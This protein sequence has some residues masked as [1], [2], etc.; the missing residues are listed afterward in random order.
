MLYSITASRSLYGMVSVDGTVYSWYLVN[1]ALWSAV[2]RAVRNLCARPAVGTRVLYT[3]YAHTFTRYVTARP[4]PQFTHRRSHAHTRAKPSAN[5]HSAIGRLLS[6]SRPGPL[7]SFMR[8]WGPR[9]SLAQSA[10]LTR[11]T[12]DRR[13]FTACSTRRTCTAYPASRCALT[14]WPRPLGR[15]RRTTLQRRC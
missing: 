8:A 7:S 15:V 2:C 14:A 5:A 3:E 9:I 6:S 13:R 11:L 12:R 10:V 4:I 1:C